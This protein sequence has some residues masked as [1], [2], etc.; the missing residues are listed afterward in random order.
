[1][2]A[3]ASGVSLGLSGGIAPPGGTAVLKLSLASPPGSEP[4][5]IQWTLTYDPS[6]VA[7]VNASAEAAAS[8]AGK[9]LQCAS[10]TGSLTCILAGMN[11]NAIP[12]GPVTDV[13]ITLS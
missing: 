2:P 13:N 4:A 9:T 7:A 10:G 12:S 3:G 8:A 1:M 5:A 11:A 6:A